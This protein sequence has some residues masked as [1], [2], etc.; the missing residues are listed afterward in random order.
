M[1]G[2]KK[3]KIDWSKKKR[4]DGKGYDGGGNPE[5]HVIKPKIK[6]RENTEDI[7]DEF[8]ECK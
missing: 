2:H 3:Q 8:E 7:D 1:H 5:R 6:W 4:N